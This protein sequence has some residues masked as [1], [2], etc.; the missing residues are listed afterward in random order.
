MH[1]I[2]SN[3]LPYKWFTQKSCVPLLSIA[4]FMYNCTLVMPERQSNTMST[5][6]KLIL[7]FLFH[8]L[9]FVLA[10]NLCV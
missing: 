9:R 4:Q 3:Y 5:E 8:L 2:I 1:P 6:N 10:V 7:I